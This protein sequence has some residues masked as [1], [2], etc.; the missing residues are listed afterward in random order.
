MKLCVNKD[1]QY[2]RILKLIWRSCF[3][4]LILKYLHVG[5]ISSLTEMTIMKFV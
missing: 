5:Q 3:D 2:D 4:T 1:D